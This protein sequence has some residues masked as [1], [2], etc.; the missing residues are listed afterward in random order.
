MGGRDPIT[1]AF[2]CCLSGYPLVGSW[3]QKQSHDLN[4]GSPTWNVGNPISSS[5]ASPNAHPICT[6]STVYW[7]TT[8]YNR[9]YDR[10][11]GYTEEGYGPISCL[12]IPWGKEK[13]K[14]MLEMPWEPWR[15]NTALTAKPE[16]SITL[17]SANTASV[18]FVYLRHLLSILGG[19]HLW[20]D[21][22]P[23]A[24]LMAGWMTKGY[25]FLRPKQP[26]QLGAWLGEWTVAK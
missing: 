6:Y 9:H 15:Q 16:I 24:V 17:I 5:T 11:W 22:F 4:P 20:A 14:D 18:P 13:W 25:P 19:Y 8:L 7:Q 12:L 1:C 2:P 3:N 21:R 23:R 26:H 10:S